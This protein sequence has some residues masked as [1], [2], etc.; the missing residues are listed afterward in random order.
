MLFR[1]ALTELK[2]KSSTRRTHPRVE[3]PPSALSAE[4]LA[5]QPETS[6]RAKHQLLCLGMEGDSQG[7]LYL[8]SHSRC[9][10][11]W[12]KWDPSPAS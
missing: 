5:S 12:W 3:I 4:I 11:G 8:S 2:A 1:G 6:F 10:W 9:P 7:T